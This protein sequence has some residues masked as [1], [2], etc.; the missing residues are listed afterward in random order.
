MEYNLCVYNIV[1]H[2]VPS[3]GHG[4]VHDVALSSYLAQAMG[5]FIVL[6]FSSFSQPL[7]GR[8]LNH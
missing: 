4:T 5:F 1:R 8:E 7:R 3:L 6:H 2:I